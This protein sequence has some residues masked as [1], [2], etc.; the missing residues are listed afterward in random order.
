MLPCYQ[1]AFRYVQVAG[2]TDV[3]TIIDSLYDE[4]VTG[5]GWTCTAGGKTQ[6]PTEFKSPARSDGAWFTVNFTRVS[7]TRL[8]WIIKDQYG[9]LVNNQTSTT[10]DI[11]ATGCGVDIHSGATHLAITTLRAT[12]ESMSCGLADQTP[13]VSD[14]IPFPILF[15]HRGARNDTGTLA[16]DRYGDTLFIRYIDSTSYSCNSTSVI[17]RGRGTSMR[18]KSQTIGGTWQFFPLELC[19]YSNNLWMGRVP[20]TVY[21]DGGQFGAGAEITIPLDG[22]TTGVFKVDGSLMHNNCRIAWRKG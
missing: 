10:Q 8:K 9:L 7:A 17:A 16:A 3:Q 20:Q 13:E 12:P 6:T 4:L 1:T 15:A 21:V 19:N 11:E 5:L 2:V 18:T 22:S 14:A